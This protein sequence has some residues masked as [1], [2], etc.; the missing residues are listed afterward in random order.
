MAREKRKPNIIF[1]IF[2]TQRWRTSPCLH[3]PV[4]EAQQARRQ[5]CQCLRLSASQERPRLRDPDRQWAAKQE[6]P[7][8]REDWRRGWSALQCRPPQPGPGAWRGQ[9]CRRRGCQM[10]RKAGGGGRAGWGC[11][12][13]RSGRWT[14]GLWVSIRRLRFQ[15]GA[16]Q[17][18]GREGKVD[19]QAAPSQEGQEVW[20]W[21]RR[22]DGQTSDPVGRQGW[23]QEGLRARRRNQS[24]IQGAPELGR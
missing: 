15:W 16:F 1:N 7:P 2:K 3:T 17:R 19:R 5:Q 10:L 8:G 6:H 14:G 12:P 18:G 22:S 21:A 9:G 20:G 4:F 13:G 23:P 11:A 24:K